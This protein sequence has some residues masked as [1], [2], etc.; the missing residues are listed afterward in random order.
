M[1]YTC[2]LC[3]AGFYIRDKQM[4]NVIV[5]CPSCHKVIGS[6]SNYGFGPIEPC[7]IYCGTTIVGEICKE[8]ETD[9]PYLLKSPLFNIDQQL[10]AGYENLGCY[11]EASKIIEPKLEI[12]ELSYDDMKQMVYSLDLESLC[13]GIR[14]EE[15]YYPERFEAAG[16][17]IIDLSQIENYG[18][19]G[20]YEIYR[21][22]WNTDKYMPIKKIVPSTGVN[23]YKIYFEMVKEI[24]QHILHEK[25]WRY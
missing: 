16:L 23:V 20:L 4:D 13:H 7:K 10:I 18:P 3:G 17:G 11:K 2:K 9:K 6:C 5:Y 21:G 12:L 19:I 14:V 8:S 1:D 24:E 15:L 22:G 25:S